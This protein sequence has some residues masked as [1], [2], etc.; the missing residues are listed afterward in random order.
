MISSPPLPF[1]RT[2]VTPGGGGGVEELFVALLSVS[3]LEEGA[4]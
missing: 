1:I 3:R 2:C 4:G